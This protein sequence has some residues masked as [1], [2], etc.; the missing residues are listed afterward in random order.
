MNKR[1]L[2]LAMTVFILVVMTLP[3][4]P[5][6]QACGCRYRRRCEPRRRIVHRCYRRWA[7]T[8][9]EPPREPEPPCQPSCEPTCES[10]PPCYKNCVPVD[11]NMKFYNASVVP[12]EGYPRP[13]PSDA[14]LTRDEEGV[15]NDTRLE[16]IYGKASMGADLVILTIGS[17]EFSTADDEISYSG[18]MWTQAINPTD[19]ENDYVKMY[20]E[21]RIDFK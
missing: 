5:S 18:T 1:V 15:Y 16:T 8:R 2:I 13:V 7:P 17:V 14:L 12:A 4:I 21:F 10:K 11:L 20:V 3:M 19:A 9:C 6:A